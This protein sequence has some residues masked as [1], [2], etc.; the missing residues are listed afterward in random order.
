MDASTAGALHESLCAL[1]KMIEDQGL[2]DIV[3]FLVTKPM[4]VASYFCTG[5]VEEVASWRHYALSVPFYTHFTS[6]IRR[7]PDVIVHRLLAAAIGRNPPALLWEAPEEGYAPCSAHRPPGSGGRLTVLC[8]SPKTSVLPVPA[9]SLCLADLDLLGSVLA[10]P[11]LVLVLNVQVKE[12]EGGL[13]SLAFT[14]PYVQVGGRGA[15]R[16]GGKKRYHPCAFCLT[17]QQYYE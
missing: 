14:H 8:L 17:R 5:E 6:P 13:P 12:R 2:V 9:V 3:Q 15:D 16:H 10:P 11:N 4:Q 7:Y 1:R